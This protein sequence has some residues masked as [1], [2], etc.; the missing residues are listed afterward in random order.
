MWQ[1]F[2]PMP[3]ASPKSFGRTPRRAPLWASREAFFAD[4]GLFVL[5][6]AGA[7]SVNLVGSLPG[8]EILLAPLLPILLLARGRRAF[9]RKYIWFYILAGAWLFGTIVADAYLGI[10]AA[11]RMK[12][13][14]RVVFFILDFIALAI[15][16][17]NRPR[18]MIVFAL[19]IVAVMLAIARQFRGEFLTQWK[20]GIASSIMIVALLASSYFYARRRYG[21]CIVI[22]LALAAANFV[23]AFRSQVVIV[24][25]SAALTLPFFNRHGTGVGARR[26]RGWDSLK[27]VALL[28]LAG[29]AVYLSTEAIKFGVEKGLFDESVAAKFE[30][31]S[32]GKFGVLFGG[33]PETLVAIRAIRDSPILGHG[34]FAVD[35]KYL[36]LEK[37]IQYEYG[38][39]ETDE[40]ED[41]V[42]NPTIPTHSHLTMA[43]VESGIFGGLLWIYVLVLT[44]RATFRIHLLRP[45][46]TPLYCYLLVNFVWDILYSPFGSVNRMWGAYLILMS[47][48]LLN[49][50]L[51]KV[52]PATMLR[53]TL[54]YPRGLVAKR[55]LGT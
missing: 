29:G 49:A 4:A 28:A 50:P 53:R 9:D 1:P 2:E 35:P 7:Y 17:N 20:F 19:S 42:E 15:L 44:I 37:D 52:V 12:G 25:V 39:T 45:A 21:V 40:L 23:F 36:A 16:L 51:H 26:T 5:G 33:R 30:S 31:Q 8:N 6:A 43:W 48:G 3:I 32:G 54:Y 41:D 18:R 22:S 47:Y 38:Y 34:S 27:V 10:P 24:L 46:L 14:A 55:Y 13:I 11:S